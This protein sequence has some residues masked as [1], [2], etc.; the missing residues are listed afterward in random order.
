M[1]PPYWPRR[2][3]VLPSF[4]KYLQKAG[5]VCLQAER[6]TL[7]FGGTVAL[8]GASLEARLGE[9]HSLVG[10]NGAGK[11]SLLNCINGLYKPTEGCIRFLGV[12]ITG[13]P[14][15]RVAA[16]GIGRAFQRLALFRGM[17]VLE[18][19]LVGRHLFIKAGPLAGAVYW[20]RG[21]REDV[22]NQALAEEILE[23]LEIEHLRHKPVRELSYGMQKRVEF[24]RALA[25]QPKLLLL[26]EP[27]AGMNLEEKQ[28]VARFILDIKEELG[29]AIILVE[30]ELDMVMDISDRVT[31]Y[32]FGQLIASGKPAEVLTH[33]AVTEAYLGQGVEQV[34]A[35]EGGEDVTS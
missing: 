7:R 9:V 8:A 29:I 35:C 21:L 26:D 27:V 30:H 22:A 14:P 12:D 4:P 13:L 18:N 17:T 25:L 28:D 20:G 19:V 6:V 11:T 16:L 1:V 3:E 24:A 32:N 23:F 34:A 10:P 31:V 5:T 2:H 33:P 15:N